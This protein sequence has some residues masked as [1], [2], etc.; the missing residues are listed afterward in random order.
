MGSWR[1]KRLEWFWGRGV[2]FFK[3]RPWS[4]R[5]HSLNSENLGDGNAESTG[6]CHRSPQQKF[7]DQWKRLESRRRAWS[8]L[9]QKSIKRM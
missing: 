1:G 3:L 9:K 2:W 4:K 7:R 5:V 6:K 8:K